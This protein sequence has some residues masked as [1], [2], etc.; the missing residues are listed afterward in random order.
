MVDL[1]EALYARG[2]SKE[3]LGLLDKAIALATKAEPDCVRRWHPEIWLAGLHMQKSVWLSAQ[4]QVAAS[5]AELRALPPTD[6]NPLEVTQ[7]RIKENGTATDPVQG[8]CL[9]R[10]AQR[11]RP[12]TDKAPLRQAQILAAQGDIAGATEALERAEAAIE[13]ELE[14]VAPR[15]PMPRCFS[16]WSTVCRISRASR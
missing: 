10:A 15:A 11:A 6:L 12:E 16:R 14:H 8:L 1:A 2:H 5:Q 7:A 3:A 13:L 4:G 9:A